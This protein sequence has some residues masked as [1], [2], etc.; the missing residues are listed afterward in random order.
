MTKKITIYQTYEVIETTVTDDTTA[1]E[2]ENLPF[3][4]GDIV[5]VDVTDAD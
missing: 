1:A 2:F 4:R 5:R 3:E